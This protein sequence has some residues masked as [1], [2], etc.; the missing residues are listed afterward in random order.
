MAL[1]LSIQFICF[2]ND[3]EVRAPSTQAG[4]PAAWLPACNW[5][6][7]CSS[8]AGQARPRGLGDGKQK[9]PA[10]REA[11]RAGRRRGEGRG[12]ELMGS[13][14]SKGLRERDRTQINQELTNGKYLKVGGNLQLCY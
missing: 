14:G 1:I 4:L 10:Q 2:H 13:S 9:F 3:T 5:S 6:V 8:T 11:G 12:A 7:D